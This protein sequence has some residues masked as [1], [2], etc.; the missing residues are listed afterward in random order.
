MSTCLHLCFAK[1]LTCTSVLFHNQYIFFSY[2]CKCKNC[3]I[4]LLVNEKEAQCCQ[5][6]EGCKD[7]LSVEL[8]IQ[9]VGEVPHCITLH[10]G[11]ASVCLTP[12]SLRQ[13]GRK[14]H[15]IDGRKYKVQG[16]ENRQVLKHMTGKQFPQIYY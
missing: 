12:W 3:K 1:I 10:P 4:D 13:A 8:V 2:R 15:K 9:E 5:E 11:F 7:A 16:D 14:F 6:I